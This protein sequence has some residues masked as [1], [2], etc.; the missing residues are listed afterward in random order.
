VKGAVRAFRDICEDYTFD[1][2]I[3][4]DE[5]ERVR[6]VKYIINRRLNQVDRTLIILY[7]DCHSLRKLGARMG[8]SRTTVQQQINRIKKEI[9]RIYDELTKK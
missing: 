2:D 7:A 4:N 6:L 9:L 5:P 1:P 8:L 3:M